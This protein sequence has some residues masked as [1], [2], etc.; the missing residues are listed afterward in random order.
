MLRNDTKYTNILIL[1]KKHFHFTDKLSSTMLLSSF[2]QEY[3][4]KSN[5]YFF[6][7]FEQF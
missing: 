7:N 6:K 4:N 5:K 1:L 2:K 3:V